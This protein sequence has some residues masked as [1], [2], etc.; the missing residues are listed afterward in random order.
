MRS[1]LLTSVALIGFQ[2]NEAYSSFGLSS[3]ND[4]Y[5]DECGSKEYCMEQVIVLSETGVVLKTQHKSLKVLS[6]KEGI[7][8]IQGQQC[9]W[10]ISHCPIAVGCNVCNYFGKICN[11]KVIGMTSD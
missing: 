4:D 10:D 9:V 5:D 3:V 7:V 2:T 6:L 1:S 8:N 11:Y